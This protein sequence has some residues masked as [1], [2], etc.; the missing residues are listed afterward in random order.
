M[1]KGEERNYSVFSESA[2]LMAPIH[3]QFILNSL[4]EAFKFIPIHWRLCPAMTQHMVLLVFLCLYNGNIIAMQIAEEWL[5][6]HLMFS[7]IQWAGISNK[8]ERRIF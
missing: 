6:K 2:A 3:L 4:R 7:R 1:T 8:H 5:P